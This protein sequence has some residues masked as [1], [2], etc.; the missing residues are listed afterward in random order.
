MR[1]GDPRAAIGAHL[2]AGANSGVLEVTPEL[3]GVEER[4]ILVDVLGSGTVASAR[5][6]TGDRIDRLV[7]GHRD[8]LHLQQGS[9][10]Q[11]GEILTTMSDNSVMWVYFNMPEKAYLEYM[12]NLSQNKDDLKIELM[13]AGGTKFNQIGKIGAIEAD[14]N[15]ENGNIPF[16]GFSEPGPPAASRW[17]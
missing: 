14:F 5:D 12:T 16:R 2:Y 6:V 10:V 1:R 8:R 9:L 13:L 11:E 4:S 3:V 7:K 15:N 17:D